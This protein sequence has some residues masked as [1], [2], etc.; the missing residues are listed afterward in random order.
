MGAVS[1]YVIFLDIAVIV[2]LARLFGLAARR[3][4]QPAVVGEIVAGI[5]LGPSLLGLLPGHLDARL[6]PADVVPYLKVLAELGLVLFMFIVGLQLDTALLRGHQ[7]RAA[8]IS[9]ASIALPFL[10]GALVTVGLHPLHD[11]VNGKKVPLLHLMLFMGVAMSITAFPVLARILSERKMNRTATGVLALSAAAIDDVLA[12]TLLAVVNAM[13]TGNGWAAAVR[14]VALSVLFVAVMFA[15]VR[16]LLARMMNWY[17]KAGRVTPEMLAVVLVGAL[18]SAF[19]TERIGIHEIFGAFL[20][21]AIMPRAGAHEF[22]REVL[23]RLE[24]VS[25]LLLLPI[26]FVVTGFGVNLRAFKRPALLWQLLLILAAAIGGKFVGAFTAA[27][28][29]RMTVQHSAAI[30]VLM[31][32]RANRVGHPVGRQAT[33]CSGHRDVHDDGDDGAVDH[34]DG[35]AAFAGR[36]SG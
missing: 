14:T 31:D 32:T 16:P 11:V 10:L 15:V 1:A 34:R 36:V 26:F 6:F 17:R 12:W 21:G 24:Q 28:I 2:V 22:R 29:Q 13:A 18:S 33:R 5:A 3:L 25:I 4:R 7:R 9:L 19:V 20:F 30:A 35:R 23:E 27:R 8:T